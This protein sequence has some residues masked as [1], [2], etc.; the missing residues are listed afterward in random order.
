MGGWAVV[1][2]VLLFLLGI[3]FTLFPI[4][5]GVVFALAGVIVYASLAGF[6]SLPLWVYVLTVVMVLANFAIDIFAST[7]GVK[8][9]GGSRQAM[10]GAAI[11]TF[12]LPFLIGP[13]LG[14]ILGPLIGAVIGELVHVRKAGHLA[15]VGLA[16]LLGF[17]TGTVLKLITIFVII[18]G[19]FIGK[20]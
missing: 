5:P 6:H 2:A 17:L 18:G 3:V 10:V 20:A 19:F 12:V 4:L 13:F 8:K 9:A 16:S 14:V 15:K 7:W 11:G 1:F